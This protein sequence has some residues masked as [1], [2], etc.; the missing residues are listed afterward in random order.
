M[1]EALITRRGGGGNLR[2]R[3]ADVHTPK[4]G[5]PVYSGDKS[6]V[7]EFS[8]DCRRYKLDVADNCFIT[9]SSN[10]YYYD[11]GIS[12]FYV[13]NAP[14]AG[15][16]LQLI[17]L[18]NSNRAMVS[19]NGDEENVEGNFVAIEVKKAPDGYMAINCKDGTTLFSGWDKVCIWTNSSWALIYITI[20]DVA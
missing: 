6:I 2:T 19:V 18:S 11:F 12:N 8:S 4:D 15:S 20:T 17:E 7:A 9:L 14:S 5:H 1:G 13:E 10:S 3:V 16:G